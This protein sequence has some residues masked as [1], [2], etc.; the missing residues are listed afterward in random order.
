[1]SLR[2]GIIDVEDGTVGRGGC[3]AVRRV[4]GNFPQPG[5]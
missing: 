5:Y 4:S 1:M 3:S 2:A